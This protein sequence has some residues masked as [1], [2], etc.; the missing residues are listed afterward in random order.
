M[1]LKSSSILSYFYTQVSG[2][3][4]KISLEKQ[5]IVNLLSFHVICINETIEN[6]QVNV[7]FS[8]IFWWLLG[9]GSR[10]SS[11]ILQLL[12][13]TFSSFWMHP[14]DCGQCT[15]VCMLWND[16]FFQ[17]GFPAFEKI[18]IA[19]SVALRAL[20]S[21]CYTELG[22]KKEIVLC[23]A[24]SEWD[25][26]ESLISKTFGSAAWS[27]SDF[28]SEKQS[29]EVQ[30]TGQQ[31]VPLPVEARYCITRILYQERTRGLLQSIC[32]F[33]S[34]FVDQKLVSETF[35]AIILSSQKKQV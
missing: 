21:I 4:Y 8:F 31:G 24:T 1:C 15:C 23:G 6:G 7:L 11:L 27:T 26:E 16:P 33:L 17:S 9:A 34:S 10:H 18:V 25:T 32:I 20:Y 29:E 28:A 14:V 30:I 19:V 3:E 22:G 12:W 35:W 13:S 2:Q 5:L